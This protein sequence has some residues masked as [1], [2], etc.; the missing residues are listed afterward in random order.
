[1]KALYTTAATATGGR[2]GKVTSDNNVLNIDVRMPKALGGANDEHLNPEMLF[3]GGYA[4]C[5]DSALNMIIKHS[6]IATGV[7]SV[8]ANVSIGQNGEGGFALAVALHAN[9]PGVSME[10]A[11]ELVHKAHAVCPY[12]NAIKGNVTVDLTVSNND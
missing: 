11:Q 7:T 8:T 5:F 9:V 2:N 3:A 10:V 6:Q 4:A 1:M 12:S